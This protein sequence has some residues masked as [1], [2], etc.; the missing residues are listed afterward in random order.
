MD[1]SKLIKQY[2]EKMFL[3][4]KEFAEQIGVSF[5][6]VNRWETEKFEP[7]M[8]IKK[9]LHDLFLKAGIVEE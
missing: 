1:Y 4:Q 9:K 3:T 2:R 8:K 5:V 7:T 6:T